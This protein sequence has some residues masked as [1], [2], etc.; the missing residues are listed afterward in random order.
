MKKLVTAAD[1]GGAPFTKADLRTVFNDE[2]WDAVEAL[3]SPYASDTEGIIVS[4]CVITN[5]AGNFDMT[6]GIC[7]LDGQFRRIAAVTN[8]TY[9]KYIYPNFISVDDTRTFA[10]GSSH[11]LFSDRIASLDVSIPVGVQYIAITN[12]TDA[13][14]RR[15]SY[16]I[17]NTPAWQNV[18]LLNGWASVTGATVQYRRNPITKVIELRGLLDA[19]SASSAI[20][21]DSPDLPD[22]D[23]AGMGVSSFKAP[24]VADNSTFACLTKVAAG[25]QITAHDTA[26]DYFLT[27][28]Q[29]ITT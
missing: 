14:D 3:L 17:N 29:Y 7:Y 24:I 5:N 15:L 19:G 6:E 18:T 10:D 9:P 22:P 23:Y 21:A 2:I 8:Q 25:W 27:G 13:N 1:L 4:G 16:F 26:R 20:F 12:L 28:V 11:V